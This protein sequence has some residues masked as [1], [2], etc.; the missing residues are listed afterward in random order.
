ME[1][2]NVVQSLS[3]YVKSVLD[4]NGDGVINFKDFLELFPNSAIGIAVL[5]V[6]LVVAVAE[7]RVWDVGYKMTGDPLKA[8]GFVLISAVPFYL[9]QIFWLY[10]VANTVQK[11]IA[12]AMVASSLYTSW[13]FGTADLSLS[14]DVTALVGMVTNMTA[15][16]IVLVLGYILWDDG[17]KANRLKKQA[18]GAAKREREYQKIARS[19]LRELAETQKLQKETEREFGEAELVQGQ[20]DRLR[21]TKKGKPAPPEFKQSNAYASETDATKDFTSRQDQK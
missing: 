6:D 5:F 17:I 1:N 9:G 10:P 12:V 3:E 14:Y 4:T 20:I 19:V 8:I 18:E 7:Y 13:V 21:G 16:Y 2:K 15:G 11:V